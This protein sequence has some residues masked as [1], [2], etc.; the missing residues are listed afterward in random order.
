[1]L[2]T[3]SIFLAGAALAFAFV[4]AV[5]RI[6]DERELPP[7]IGMS[8]APCAQFDRSDARQQRYYDWAKLCEF[9]ADNARILQSG[10]RPK[11]VLL[12]DSLTWRWQIDEPDIAKR[13]IP[14][15]TS[16]QLLVRFRSDVVALRPQVVHILVGTNDIA[17]NDSASSPQRV[18]A[19]ISSMVDLA[20]AND[21]VPIVATVPPARSNSWPDGVKPYPWIDVLNTQIRALA[22]ERELVLADYHAVLAGPD[23]RFPQELAEDEAHPN[24]SGYARMRPVLDQAIIRATRD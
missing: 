3:L 11:V 15:Q 21:I 24:Q 2:R 17:G 14:G 8:E 23:G 6:F 20:L 1:M 10:T 12:G 19:H 4:Y 18:T 7:N 16:A 22:E 5:S 13:G 9:G